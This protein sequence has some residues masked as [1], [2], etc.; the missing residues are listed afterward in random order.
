MERAEGIPFGTRGFFSGPQPAPV[1]SSPAYYACSRRRELL[2]GLAC[3]FLR[4]CYH[5]GRNV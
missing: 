1:N 4:Q 3:Y 2:G 5:T